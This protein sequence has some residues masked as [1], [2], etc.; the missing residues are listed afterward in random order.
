MSLITATTWVPRG[1]AAQF[2]TKYEFNQEEFDRISALAKQQLSSALEDLDDA[3]RNADGTVE[4]GEEEDEEMKE[5]V[6]AS[7]NG[8]AKSS[9]KKQNG[10][11]VSNT[12]G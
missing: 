3:R 8:V 6:T 1:F 4:E 2:P 10:G 5:T 12:N 11:A 7:E 9:K